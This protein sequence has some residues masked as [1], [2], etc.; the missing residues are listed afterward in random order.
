MGSI[1]GLG[2]WVKHL[3]LLSAVVVGY[4][5]GSDPPLL[6]LWCGLAAAAAIQP[7]AWK[8]P[9]AVGVALKSQ[10]AKKTKNKTNKQLLKSN[11]TV[12]LWNRCW[13]IL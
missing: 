2:E 5:Y 6:C 7:V 9:Y 13:E 8:L 10:N 11:D 1:P 3:A 4:R 12:V